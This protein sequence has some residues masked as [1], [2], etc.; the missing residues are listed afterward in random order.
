MCYLP[1]ALRRFRPVLQFLAVTVLFNGGALQPLTAQVKPSELQVVIEDARPTGDATHGIRFQVTLRNTGSAPL[2]LNGG[3]LL[4]NGRQGWSA[5]TCDL[6]SAAGTVVPLG[7]HWQMG[8]VAG[9]VYFLGVPLRPGDSHTL[10][11]TPADYHVGTQ[12]QPGRYELRC[13]FTGKPSEFRDATQLPAAW[14]GVAT[15][16]AVPITLGA[17]K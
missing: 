17:A 5:V 15:S 16:T 14:E 3:A 2:L 12:V 6:R 7:L 1:D 8:G 10:T 13:T 9:R 11:V 4:G